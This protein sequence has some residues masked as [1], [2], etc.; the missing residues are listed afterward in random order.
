MIES[1]KVSIAHLG[2]RMGLED[3][4]TLCQRCHELVSERLGD[5]TRGEERPA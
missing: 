2:S 4:T 1:T 3:L 5:T